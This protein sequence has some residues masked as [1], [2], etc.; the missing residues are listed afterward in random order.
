MDD[1][2]TSLS[3]MKSFSWTKSSK[4]NL[5]LFYYL[6][7]T[8]TILIMINAL[9]MWLFV[10]LIIMIFVISPVYMSLQ[11][12]YSIV[13]ESYGYF[14][15]M[16]FLHGYPPVIFI[17]LVILILLLY[18]VF[19]K[20]VLDSL[21]KSTVKTSTNIGSRSYEY[22]IVSCFISSCQHHRNSWC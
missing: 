6:F 4:A 21:I 1:S 5:F 22:D 15:S 2:D 13:S 3:K 16:M 10:F 11:K 17:G 8:K 7:Q 9:S 12:D 18:L 19:C 14:A 20:R